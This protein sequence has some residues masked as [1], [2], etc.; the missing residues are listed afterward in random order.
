MEKLISKTRNRSFLNSA[1]FG[2]ML[3]ALLFSTV[4][5]GKKS[6]KNAGYHNGG[7]YNPNNP[8]GGYYNA[9]PGLKAI[10][11][12][13]AGSMELTLTFSSYGSGY[14][15]SYYS[16]GQV[17]AQGQLKVAVAVPCGGT[18]LQPGVYQVATVQPGYA[19][20]GVIQGLYM[21]SG[22]ATLE[23][24][25]TIVEANPKYT[26]STGAYGF[27]EMNASVAVCGNSLYFG[28]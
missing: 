24:Y 26:S 17:V 27:D 22:P 18:Y 14:Q 12:D 13:G 28:V 7:Y 23:F 11:V 4:G 1:L 20:N 16:N 3:V 25:G 2:L 10:G 5:C 15:M 19:N 21:Q 8:G 9:G 6:S